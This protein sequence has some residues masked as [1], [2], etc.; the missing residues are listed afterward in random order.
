MG[1]SRTRPGIS[2]LVAGQRR[3]KSKA[4]DTFVLLPKFAFSSK[5]VNDMASCQSPSSI[6]H[7]A[8]WPDN[9]DKKKRALRNAVVQ[10]A[11]PV[12]DY[13]PKRTTQS[14]ARLPAKGLE[15]SQMTCTDDMY[16]GNT[17]HNI[18]KPNV[19]MMIK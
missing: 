5:S 4:L 13:P 12:V 3:R 18:A 1:E 6:P 10:D 15:S 7:V 8:P 19:D 14:P 11:Y 9:N 16:R 2:V 17:D